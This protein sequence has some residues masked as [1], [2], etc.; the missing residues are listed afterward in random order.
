MSLAIMAAIGGMHSDIHHDPKRGHRNSEPKNSY[1]LTT[2]QV[3]Q[4]STMTPKQKKKFISDIIQA[5][6]EYKNALDSKSTT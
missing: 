5:R 1:D 3:N 6:K 4:M 2:E